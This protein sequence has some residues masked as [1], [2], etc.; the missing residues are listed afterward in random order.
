MTNTPRPAAWPTLAAALHQ[1]RVVQATY[2][3]EQRLLCPH[4]LGYKHGRPKVLAYQS[5]G[6]TPGWRS[7]FIDDLHD[8]VIVDHPWQTADNYTPNSNGIDIIA[9]AIT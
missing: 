2:H 8:P 7:L 3:D 9:L 1:R 5:S 6:T 4:A